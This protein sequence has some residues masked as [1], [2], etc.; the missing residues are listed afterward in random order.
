M[1]AVSQRSFWRDRPWWIPHFLGSVPEID[2]RLLNLLGLVSLALFF[3]QYDASLLSSALKYIA[4][5][6]GMAEADLGRNMGIIRLGALPSLLVLPLADRLGRRRIFLAS[7][8]GYSLTTCATAFMNSPAA[9]VAMQMACRSF[10]VAAAATSVVIITEEFPATHR[11]WAIGMM[12]ALAACGHGFGAGVFSSIE[13]LPYGW[14]ALYFF[15]L[16]PL[17]LF[18]VLRRSIPETRRYQLY[19]AERDLHGD[20]GGG[21]AGW[22]KPLLSLATGYPARTLGVTLMALLSALAAASVFQ[23]YGYYILTNHG[24]GPGRLATM[25]I[26][27]GAVGVIGSVVA[28]RLADRVGRRAVASG[29]MFLFPAAVWC[30]FRGEGWMLPV[31]WMMIVFMW[32]ACEVMLKAFATELFPT[33]YRGTA[34]GWAHFVQ[35]IG[36]TGGLW[37]L[38]TSRETLGGMAAATSWLS[39]LARGGAV[40]G[41][42]LPETRHRELEDISREGGARAPSA[43]SP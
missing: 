10:M 39:L 38:G 15:G 8:L 40:A 7:V 19:R 20:T 34:A 6:L 33:S 36:W 42:F 25:I 1:A 11:G 29:F 37:L 9:F 16:L 26:L 28:G 22:L 18:P 35:T 17:A 31:G 2:K 13:I 32:M 24:W 30:F 43:V 23:F 41:L 21:T 14:R 27:A 3:E 5:D 12:G 4:E